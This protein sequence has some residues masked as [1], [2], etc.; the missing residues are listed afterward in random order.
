MSTLRT[1]IYHDTFGA[2]AITFSIIL[3]NY[4]AFYSSFQAIFDMLMTLDL[5]VHSACSLNC[6]WT[7]MLNHNACS[8]TSYYKWVLWFLTASAYRELEK[9][10]QWSVKPLNL[11]SKRNVDVT[12]HRLKPFSINYA[13]FN[14]RRTIYFKWTVARPWLGHRSNAERFLSL[15]LFTAYDNIMSHIIFWHLSLFYIN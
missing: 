13:S 12:C 10:M 1:F 9:N 6:K 7:R 11:F 4:D 14:I 15:F 5:R 3:N 2:A 8:P